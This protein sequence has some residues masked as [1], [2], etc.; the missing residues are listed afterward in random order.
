MTCHAKPCRCVG[1][2]RSF[3]EA[4]G[5]EHAERP[6]TSDGT[7]YLYAHD[8]PR[9]PNCRAWKM[10]GGFVVEKT[11]AGP[12]RGIGVFVEATEQ[13][14]L[15]I[16]RDMIVLVGKHALAPGLSSPPFAPQPIVGIA[17]WR[18]PVPQWQIEDGETDRRQALVLSVD[19]RTGQNVATNAKAFLLCAGC[20]GIVETTPEAVVEARAKFAKNQET[21]R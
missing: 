10:R 13:R 20:E 18:V 6:S 16:E 4:F 2:P 14:G 7:H 21:D 3:A 1:S 5:W 19:S 9:C 12:W 15:R 11:S 8:G 17:R